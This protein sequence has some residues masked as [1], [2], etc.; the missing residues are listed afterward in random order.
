M[1]TLAYMVP[2][3]MQFWD[4]YVY[5]LYLIHLLHCYNN[6]IIISLP[7]LRDVSLYVGFTLVFGPLVVFGLL[8]VYLFTVG[9]VC[10]VMR[11]CKFY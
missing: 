6:N 3:I 1:Q 4:M 9:L 8:V 10:L 2:Y 11:L 5:K 7:F